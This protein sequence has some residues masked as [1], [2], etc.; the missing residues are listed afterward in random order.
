[1]NAS[2]WSPVVAVISCN[3]ARFEV[4]PERS[5]DH[6][7]DQYAFF[8]GTANQEFLQHRVEPDR[9]DRRRLQTETRPPSL[10]TR[11]L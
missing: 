4:L 2:R 10:S 3:S 8:L 6:L 1:M 7:G 5:A 9:L 11:S